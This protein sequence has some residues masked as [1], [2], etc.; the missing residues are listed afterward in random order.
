M[1]QRG[2]A[3]ERGEPS[4]VRFSIQETVTM[5]TLSI[6]RNW[7]TAGIAAASLCTNA[8]YFEEQWDLCWDQVLLKEASV[9]PT[10]PSM[11]MH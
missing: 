8:A 11:A 6:T 7:V 2:R 3:G 1:I 5:K 10:Q 9:F 4:A